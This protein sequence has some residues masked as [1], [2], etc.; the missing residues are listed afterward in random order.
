MK[1][2]AFA[3]GTHKIDKKIHYPALLTL[4]ANVIAKSTTINERKYNL[5]GVLSHLGTHATNGHYT[6]DIK[7][8]GH[9]YHYDDSN[10]YK[11]SIESVL[12]QEAYLLFYEQA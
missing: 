9:W 3:E 1:R 6:C 11:T 8:K 5:Y 10:V 12:D 4:P 7:Q 2:F